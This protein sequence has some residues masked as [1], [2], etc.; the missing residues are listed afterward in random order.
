MGTIG[1][2]P[3]HPARTLHRLV[4]WWTIFIG[5]WFD[6]VP[7]WRFPATW[8]VSLFAEKRREAGSSSSL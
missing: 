4:V 2:A 1:Q 5:V 7:Y 6:V 8:V 3:D